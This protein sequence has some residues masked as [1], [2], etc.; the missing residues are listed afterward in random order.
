MGEKVKKSEKNKLCKKRGRETK[1]WDFIPDT[2]RQKDKE[3]KK[4]ETEIV[5]CTLQAMGFIEHQ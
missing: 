3:N 4:N 2:I 5:T 1:H